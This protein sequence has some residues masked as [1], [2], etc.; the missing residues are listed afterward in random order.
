MPR[1]DGILAESTTNHGDYFMS[2][3]TTIDVQIKD[4][5]ALRHACQEMALVLADNCEARGYAE[6]KVAAD[7]VIK[8]NGP[9]DVAV[10][11]QP[12]GAYTLVADLWCG[13]VENELG[14]DFGRIKQ[15]YGV[16]KATLEARQRGLHVRRHQHKDGK[17]RLTIGG[18]A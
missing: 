2:H 4:I 13:H 9:Y 15:L 1:L 7:H 8:L 6:N 16:H 3:F 12:N 11:R 10:Q 5:A 18:V 14:K 17:I